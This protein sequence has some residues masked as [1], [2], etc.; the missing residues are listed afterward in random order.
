MS[1]TLSQVAGNAPDGVAALR[2]PPRVKTRR[3]LKGHFAKVS[4]L[5]WAQDS[6]TLVSAGQDG[7][8]LLWNAVTAN[9]VQSIPLKSSYVMSVG[10][11]PQGR[12]VACGG[13]DNLCTIYNLAS[14]NSEPTEMASH[15]GFLS[16]CR[17]VSNEQIITSS[18]DSTCILWDISNQKPL[19]RFE[20][21]ERDVMF[22]SLKPNDSQI[23]V[24]GSVDGTA[25]LWDSRL[26][27]KSQQTYSHPQSDVNGVEFLNANAFASVGSDG[28]ARLFDIRSANQVAKFTGFTA[29]SGNGGI[30]GVEE[31]NLGFICLSASASGRLLFCGDAN[32]NISCF[33]VLNERTGPAYVLTAAHERYISACAVSPKGD[34]LA[35]GSWDKVVKIWA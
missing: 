15:D 31:E 13:L 26:G 23:F 32:G 6:R 18:G 29:A 9:K 22:L 25:K 10:L 8:L 4:A 20:E 30:A 12:L 1:S 14:K 24:S 21:H 35:T 17:F 3:L 27:E 16:C 11:E 28:T 34:A 19:V 5:H 2:A 33:D 7:N